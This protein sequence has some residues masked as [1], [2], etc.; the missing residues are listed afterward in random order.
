MKQLL[1]VLMGALIMSGYFIYESII[2]GT[3]VWFTWTV[4]SLGTFTTL[5]NILWIQAVGILFIWKIFRFDASKISPTVSL[6][7]KPKN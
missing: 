7:N 3:V 4:T 1:H 5:G 2:F 6:T